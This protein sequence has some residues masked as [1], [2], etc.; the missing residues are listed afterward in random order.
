MVER[1][2]EEKSQKEEDDAFLFVF[3]FLLYN[4]TA[5][6]ENEANVPKTAVP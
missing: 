2:L 1:P 6:A 3:H 4:Q 5:K